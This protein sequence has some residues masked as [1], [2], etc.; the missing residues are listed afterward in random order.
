MNGSPW[1]CAIH[2][3]QNCE[4][5]P[6]FTKLFLGLS[7]ISAETWA[8]SKVRSPADFSFLV[9]WVSCPSGRKEEKGCCYSFLLL[10][11]N[12]RS[13]PNP[14]VHFHGQLVLKVCQILCHMWPSHALWDIWHPSNQAP[15]VTDIPQ[16]LWK[17]KSSLPHL[18]T[19]TQKLVSPP[20]P[21]TVKDYTIV[22]ICFHRQTSLLRRAGTFSYTNLHSQCPAQYPAL[23]WLESF[24]LNWKRALQDWAGQLAHQDANWPNGW[25]EFA[26]TSAAGREPCNS[27]LPK[28][29]APCPWNAPLTWR[30]SACT[31][32]VYSPP[33]ETIF[34]ARPTPSTSSHRLPFSYAW[35]A[36]WPASCTGREEQGNTCADK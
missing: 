16:L 35:R 33:T 24:A 20:H 21:I 34:T 13:S 32:W 9:L 25:L 17:P 8:L 36:G 12:E 1:S 14:L 4:W 19:C 27:P 7:W 2:N 22:G 29:T 11:S 5:S 6:Y 3:L 18:Q 28:P 26:P 10:P 31:Q 15:N 23:E 30:A